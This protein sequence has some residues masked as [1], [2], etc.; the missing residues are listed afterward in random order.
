MVGAIAFSIHA[1]SSLLNVLKSFSFGALGFG[2]SRWPP[3]AG[4]PCQVWQPSSFRAKS[5]GSR[6]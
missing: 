5:F 2:V 1:R 3:L 4:S 6:H